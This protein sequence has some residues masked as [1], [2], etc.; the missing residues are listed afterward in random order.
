MGIHYYNNSGYADPTAYEAIKNVEEGEKRLRVAYPSGHIDLRLERFFPCTLEKAKKLFR[1]MNKTSSKADQ[2]KLYKFLLQHE[3]KFK[4]QVDS[5]L[6]Q[7]KAAIKRGDIGAFES[8]ARIAAMQMKRTQRNR[9]LLC[10][11]CGLEVE[12]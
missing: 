10:Q 4:A 8:N 6:G 1:L 11:I 5:N 9:E 7:A 2:M 3:A 12:E